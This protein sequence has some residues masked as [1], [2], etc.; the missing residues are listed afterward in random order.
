MSDGQ[1]M[2][3]RESSGV[4]MGSSKRR[5]VNLWCEEKKHQDVKRRMDKITPGRE[6]V[7][8][9]HQT[10][11]PPYPSSPTTPATASSTQRLSWGK[12]S[13]SGPSSCSPLQRRSRYSS[14]GSSASPRETDPRGRPVGR[15]APRSRRSCCHALDK[16]R[17]VI[18]RSL[19][20]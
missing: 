8:D 14:R 6:I 16:A 2:N 3:H 7:R 12:P 9:S 10:R 13:Q 18:K 19:I 20:I 17:I 4:R 11:P 5:S 1:K 15:T